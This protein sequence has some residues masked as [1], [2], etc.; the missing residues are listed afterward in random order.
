MIGGKGTVV[1]AD[2]AAQYLLKVV[3]QDTR[4][5]YYDAIDTSAAS[6]L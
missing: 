6:D 1:N 5:V 3:Y 2:R 4:A